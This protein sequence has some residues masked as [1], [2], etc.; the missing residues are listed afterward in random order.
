M[1]QSLVS[2]SLFSL[3]MPRAAPYNTRMS[4][5]E[6]LNNLVQAMP[7]DKAEALLAYAEFLNSGEDVEF[8]RSVGK[9]GLS[10]AYGSYEPE[11]STAD[12]KVERR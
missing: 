4:I 12:A 5:R 9:L 7:E 3:S 8:H 2:F 6:T 11:Y 1:G 10:K